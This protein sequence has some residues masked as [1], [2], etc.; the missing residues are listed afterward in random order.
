MLNLPPFDWLIAAL[1]SFRLTRLVGTDRIA[2]PI[3]RLLLD[4]G[5]GRTLDFLIC[6]WCLGMW[7][8]AG[9]VASS[10]LWWN[11]VRYL[12]IVLALSAIVGLIAE[13]S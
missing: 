2:L 4:R 9:V 8:S 10:L 12:W 6:P 3:R 1:A 7:L 11:Q 13:R 5:W